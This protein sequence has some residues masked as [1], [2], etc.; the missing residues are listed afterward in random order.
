MRDRYALG[1]KHWCDLPP[2]AV[3]QGPDEPA[4]LL[5]AGFVHVCRSCGAPW[6]VKTARRTTNRQWAPIRRRDLIARFRAAITDTGA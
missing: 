3:I 6:K 1:G 5:P 4:T 2:L